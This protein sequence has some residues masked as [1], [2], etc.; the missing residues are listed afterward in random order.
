MDLGYGTQLKLEDDSYLLLE[1]TEGMFPIYLA[2]EDSMQDEVTRT[3]EIQIIPKAFDEDP[4]RYLL[5]GSPA[6][7][8]NQLLA[9]SENIGIVIDNRDGQE[10]QTL[11]AEDGSRFIYDDITESLSDASALT[12]VYVDLAYGTNRAASFTVQ[13]AGVVNSTG[14]ELFELLTEDGNKYR[15]ESTGE[16]FE[17]ATEDG[18]PYLLEQSYLSNQKFVTQE[19]ADTN[20]GSIYILEQFVL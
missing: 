8:Q 9:H 13:G 11:F 3:T 7:S 16:L 4:K 18:R 17:L 15:T 14:A 12:P 2:M 5:T 1:R 20:R 10:D 19:S 6:T